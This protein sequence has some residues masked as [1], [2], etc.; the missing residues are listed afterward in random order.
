[1]TSPHTDDSPI[2]WKPRYTI[3]E[4][5]FLLGESRAR[6]YAK[7]RTGRYSVTKDGKRTYMTVEQLHDA[8]QGDRQANTR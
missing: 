7:V 2:G 8:A 5:L 3:D 1:M 4:C 6:F